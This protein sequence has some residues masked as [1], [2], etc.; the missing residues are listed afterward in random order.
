MRSMLQLLGGV[1]VAGAVAAGSTAFTAGAV[2]DKTNVN[3]LVVGGK[4]NVSISGARL[5]KA[6]F[7]SD[8]TDLDHIRGITITIDGGCPSTVLDTTSTVKAAFNGTPQGT[9]PATG[10]F[11][12]CSLNSGSEWDCTITGGASN[13][14]SAITSVDIAVAPVIV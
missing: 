8:T 7:I 3:T 2:L 10:V 12:S 1:A 4:N 5:M 14:Y 6:N 9:A 13:Y 11:F